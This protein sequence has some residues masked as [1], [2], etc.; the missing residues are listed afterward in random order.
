[1]T[2]V[3]LHPT[4]R[5]RDVLA[6]QV[7]M[8]GLSL[9]PEVLVV[10]VVITILT[11]IIGIDIG[12]GTAASWFDSDE[13]VGF[14]VISFLLPFAVWRKERRFGPAFLWTLPVDRRRLALARVFGGWVW[15]MAALTFF[16]LWQVVLAALSGV[17]GAETVSPLAFT[18]TTS[19]YLFGSALVLGLRHPLRW[20]LGTFGVF[21]LLAS[22]NEAL[23]PA[24]VGAAG[25]VAWSG[26]LRWLVYGPYGLDTL[27]GSRPLD[28]AANQWAT[29]PYFAQWAI[30]T[31]LSLAAGAAAL[32]A[33]AS[34]HRERRRH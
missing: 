9:H 20:L 26:V 30:P 17:E 6:E 28:R 18:G 12:Q 31:V 7:R 14:G 10:A 15:L 2:E 4:P 13:W 22:L 5:W 23:G 34:R 25:I 27:L 19:T 1:M 33:A 21:F 11:V 24:D 3:T 32:W 16:V 29:L 8:V